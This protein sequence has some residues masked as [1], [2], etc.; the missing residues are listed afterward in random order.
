MDCDTLFLF[1][2]CVLLSFTIEIFCRSNLTMHQELGKF[3]FEKRQGKAN[4]KKIGKNMSIVQ[5]NTEN[6]VEHSSKIE[7]MKAALEGDITI[8]PQF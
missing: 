1:L 6:K 7:Q 3:E 8:L 4:I 5:V 2:C